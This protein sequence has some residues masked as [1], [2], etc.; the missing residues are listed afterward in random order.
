MSWATPKNIGTLHAQ[1]RTHTHTLTKNK[2]FDTFSL[3]L[4]IFLHFIL[5]QITNWNTLIFGLNQLAS[6]LFIYD[7][8]WRLRIKRSELVVSHNEQEDQ[9][10]LLLPPNTYSYYNPLVIYHF[11]TARYLPVRRRHP[12]LLLLLHLR[13]TFCPL[14]F[15][16]ARSCRILERHRR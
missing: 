7:D 14:I 6:K 15:C 8:D 1:P 2:Q 9:L 16:W 10:A 3:A 13:L 11:A 4:I 5:I 12:L